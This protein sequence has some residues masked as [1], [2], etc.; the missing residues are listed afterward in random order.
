MNTHNSRILSVVLILFI[1][2]LAGCS[3]SNTNEVY[4]NK[5]TYDDVIPT[6]D[7]LLDIAVS[8]KDYTIRD[9][10]LTDDEYD[11]INYYKDN[12]IKIID[13]PYLMDNDYYIIDGVEYSISN[14]AYDIKLIEEIFN[15]SVE[16]ITYNTMSEVISALQSGDADILTEVLI[17]DSLPTG[18][19]SIEVGSIDRSKYYYTNY[20]TPETAFIE[21][22]LL[23]ESERIIGVESGYNE[24]SDTFIDTYGLQIIEYS[25]INDVTNAINNGTIKGY[26][27]GQINVELYGLFGMS[28]ISRYNIENMY[29]ISYRN[30]DDTLSNFASAVH[31]LFLNDTRYNYNRLK[32]VLHIIEGTYLTDSEKAVIEHFTNT[33]LQV[34]MPPASYPDAYIDSNGLNAGIAVDSFEYKAK[35]L[36]INYEVVT[37]ADSTFDEIIARLGGG[38][39]TPTSDVAVGIWNT[40][41]RE[42]FISYTY[43]LFDVNFVLVGRAGTGTISNLDEVSRLDIGVVTGYGYFDTILNVAFSPDKEYPEY[44]SED[45]LVRAFINNEIDYFIISERN[46][47]IYQNRY[48][49]YDSQVKYKFDADTYVAFGFSQTAYTADLVS[50][51][52]KLEQIDKI[53]KYLD[54][55]DTSVSIEDILEYENILATRNVIFAGIGFL[56]IASTTVAIIVYKQRENTKKDARTDKLTGIGNRRAFFEDFTNANL[57]KYKLLFI[58]LT[59]FKYANDTYGH[60]F[61][62][63][64]LQVVSKRLSEI[65]GKAKCYRLGGDEF[66]A[67]LPVSLSV[68]IDKILNDI[69]APM[70]TD[71]TENINTFSYNI[72]FACGIVDLSKFRELNNLDEILRY[73]DLAMYNAKK[74]VYSSVSYT[75]VNSEFMDRFK[76]DTEIE[77]KI[78][79][80][81][82]EDIFVAMY[83]PLIEI[84]SG[85]V[86]G[87]ESLVRYK[88]DLS[89]S[90][91]EF[92]GAVIKTGKIKEMDLFMLEESIKTFDELLSNKYI[93]EN[94]IIGVN[95]GALTLAEITKKEI[96]NILSRYNVNKSNICIEVS[97][98][99]LSS[100]R[101][102]NKIAKIRNFGYKIAIDN[103][104]AG[105]SSLSLLS[106]L[107]VDI[108]KIDRSLISG[109]KLN[110]NEV[111]K[112]QVV[113]KSVINLSK[114]LGF[115]VVS[116]GVESKKE[117]DCLEKFGVDIVQGYYLSRPVDRDGLIKWI[118]KTNKIK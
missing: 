25:N 108:I 33:P 44:A 14:Y 11:A 24:I 80:E 22:L 45:E 116:E 62:D 40:P 74:R 8:D 64:I 106:S 89:L 52:N 57:C 67:V 82:P 30:S 13:L 90:P 46:L 79:Q 111:T 101:I 81:K 12:P 66:I 65:D 1:F 91:G 35:I 68:D 10:G 86:I 94:S 23:E 17:T 2:L 32:H 110:S 100:R 83:Q 41:Q 84:K 42:E 73:A 48:K 72:S 4:L 114:E 96:Y 49:I 6:A 55:Y 92:L 98:D 85:K 105:N 87:F 21:L 16:T 51:F 70:D 109:C 104:T 29:T 75:E 69:S 7:T 88:N 37:S 3:D 36:G 34:E 31:K 26:I 77:L 20:A 63:L 54:Y 78:V 107:D 27:S 53:S 71:L 9:L 28:D 118:Q 56:L 15:I 18:I 47:S 99:T 59:K 60:D 76:K 38:G 113:Y 5:A 102:L 93:D 58:D 43:P 61:G 97:E 95:F 117:A 103:F 19:S 112:N 115:S 39:N 50:I